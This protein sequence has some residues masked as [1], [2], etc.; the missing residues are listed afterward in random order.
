MRRSSGG[1][2]AAS[3][4]SGP[5][6]GFRSRPG[7]PIGWPRGGRVRET[8][9]RLLSF[10]FV[11]LPLMIQRRFRKYSDDK[12]PS[13]RGNGLGN[14]EEKVEGKLWLVG[15]SFFGDHLFSNY[16]ASRTRE[17]ERGDGRWVS[18]WRVLFLV[19]QG[20]M[21]RQGAFGP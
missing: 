20:K 10:F 16:V 1:P 5:P 21:A 15:D 19:F 6:G 13:K 11:F 3:C 9:W 18:R 17:R 14:V 12:T 2:G 4:R 8:G 7:G